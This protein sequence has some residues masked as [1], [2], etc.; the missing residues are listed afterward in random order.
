MTEREL[1][2]MALQQ[3][4]VQ[5]VARGVD[6]ETIEEAVERAITRGQEEVEALRAAF[7]MAD[8]DSPL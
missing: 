4:V 8:P 7:G 1:W 3:A 5:L 6:H 2:L